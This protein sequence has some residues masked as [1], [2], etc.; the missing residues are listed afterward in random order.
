MN[1]ECELILSSDFLGENS[2][3]SKL[4]L[5]G[6]PLCFTIEL[7][8]EG[9]IEKGISCIPRN[10]EYTLRINTD[11]GMNSEY[12]KRFP[13]FHEGMIEVVGFDNDEHGTPLFRYVYFHCGNIYKETK[14]CI[15]VNA[16]YY[17][18]LKNKKIV[19]YAGIASE[20]AYRLIYPILLDR[21]KKGHNKLMV[22][23]RHDA[24]LNKVVPKKI[25]T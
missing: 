14:G 9:K 25:I 12:K 3:L 19:D 22:V 16:N 7:K 17:P 10:K 18:I 5:N 15:L 21:I 20:K 1:S 4:I 2:T 8:I 23:D 13:E 24:S 11:G 6:E